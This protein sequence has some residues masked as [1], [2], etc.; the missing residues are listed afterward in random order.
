MTHDRT[1]LV[2]PAPPRSTTG[3]RGA[4]IVLL[5]TM[6]AGLAFDLSTK[7]WAFRTIADAPV[8]IA[9]R[10]VID[11]GARAS[12][13][14]LLPPHDPVVIVPGVLELKLVLN[15]GAVFGMGAGKRWF[16]VAFTVAAVG[17]C[18]W[19]FARWTTPRQRWAHAALGLILAGGLGNLYDRLVFACVRDF[20]HP[21]P[22]VMLPWGL[23][24]PW[25]GRDLW[26]YVSN[27]ADKLLLIGIGILMVHL[28]RTPAP[29][30][31]AR[32]GVTPTRG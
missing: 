8:S 26:S 20:I 17:F 27:A 21:L 23:E 28:W 9:R 3:S 19:M 11:V 7:S 10:E 30:R 2:Q 25:G 14:V 16:F 22:G 5:A 12:L 29:G 1:P 13:E 32:P 24:W 18:L 15:R 6:V 4:W 31:D